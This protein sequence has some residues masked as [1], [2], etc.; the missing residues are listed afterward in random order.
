MKKTKGILGYLFILCVVTP[1]FFSGC[2]SPNQSITHDGKTRTY[3]VHLP[4][5][6]TTH[7]EF[8]LVIVLHGGGGNA[9]QMQ[10]H[11][12]MNKKADDEGF[13]VVYPDG[14]G[15]LKDRLLTWNA[16]YC[17]AN[18]YENNIDDVGFIRALIE[19]LEQTL[20]IDSNRIYVT[21]ISNGAMLAYT[22][23]SELSDLIAAIAPVAGSIGGNA[24]EDSPRWIIPD[25]TYPVAVI[26]FHGMEDKRVPYE[27]G[28]PT[29][30][31]TWGAYSYLS[32]NDSISFWVEQ[33]NCSTTPQTTVSE[34]GNIIINTYTAQGTNADVVL[35]TIIDGGHAWPGG[36]IGGFPGADIPTQEISA[37][38]I[39]W[40]F[41]ENHPKH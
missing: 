5:S 16:G 34:S 24:T 17:C 25:P 40:E 13:I 6:Y 9:E 26:A 4:L 7:D 8:P 1:S 29:A 28:I 18:A 20:H 15:V 12:G 38:D 39:M 32:V 37:T 22:I 14:T 19:K 3:Q 10:E 23:G 27:G 33:N 31:L 11:G 41:F 30:S 2:T 36:D 35:Y 21:G